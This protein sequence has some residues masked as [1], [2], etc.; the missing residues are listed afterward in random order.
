MKLRPRSAL[1]RGWTSSL[2]PEIPRACSPFIL[3]P[4]LSPLSHFL[5]LATLIQPKVTFP[6]FPLWKGL[7]GWL[8]KPGQ[9]EIL[10]FGALGRRHFSFLFFSPFL[11]SCPVV[12]P[13]T[14]TPIPAREMALK[15]A[16]FEIY[17]YCCFLCI[18]SRAVI[19]RG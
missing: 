18:F 11:H 7:A 15:S 2:F 1:V 4:R 12:F 16:N 19:R 13:P 3:H 8:P 5:L 17:S 14:Y 9:K 10:S 6:P